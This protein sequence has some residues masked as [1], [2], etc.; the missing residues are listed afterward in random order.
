MYAVLALCGKAQ[1]SITPYILLVPLSLIQIMLLSLGVGVMISALTTKYR[2]LAMVVG[3]G[4]TLWQYATP[5]AY[6]FA[7]VKDGAYRFLYLLNPVTPAILTFRYGLFG[8]GYFDIKY[9]LISWAMTVVIA[10]IGVLLFNRIEKNFAD[11]V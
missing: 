5:V 8:T 3:F 9:Y 10:L 7:L 11:T 2:D 4:L 1:L 6:G